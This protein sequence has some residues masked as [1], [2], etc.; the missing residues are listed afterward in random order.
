MILF[1][2]AKDIE[3]TEQT[4]SFTLQ[5]FDNEATTNIGVTIP[6]DDN[7]SSLIEDLIYDEQELWND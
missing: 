5:F 2:Y 7:L 3:Y 6:L 1:P 4:L